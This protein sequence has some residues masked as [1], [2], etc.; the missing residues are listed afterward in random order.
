MTSE[1][2][3]CSWY[4]RGGRQ[5]LEGRGL[6]H[7]RWKGRAREEELGTDKPWAGEHVGGGSV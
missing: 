7:G 6:L 1:V 3:A 2:L 4:S 5:L